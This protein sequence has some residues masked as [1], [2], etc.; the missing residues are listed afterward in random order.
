MKAKTLATVVSAVFAV[1]TI[2]GCTS[3]TLAPTTIPKAN[4]DCTLERK[5]EVSEDQPILVFSG[6][7]TYEVEPEVARGYDNI[8]IVNGE[9]VSMRHQLPRSN[10]LRQEYVPGPET[11]KR[12]ADGATLN[13]LSY[14]KSVSNEAKVAFCIDPPSVPK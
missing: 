2:A 14:W 9:I 8:F 1:V 12:L 4:A 3:P 7:K 13:F 11:R 5:V 6:G 10:D